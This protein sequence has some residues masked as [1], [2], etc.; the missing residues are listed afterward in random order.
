MSL[1]V[2]LIQSQ[3]KYIIHNTRQ[4]T[5][6]RQPISKPVQR[7]G[8]SV[9][10]IDSKLRGAPQQSVIRRRSGLTLRRRASEVNWVVY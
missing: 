1:H 3:V 7:I 2:A 5:C 8:T 10:D 4:R 6:R 9:A